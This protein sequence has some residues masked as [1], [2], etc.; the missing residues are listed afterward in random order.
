M[1]R[2]YLAEREKAL[3]TDILFLS[4]QGGSLDRHDILKTVARIA[5]R[6]KVL[7]AHPHRFRHTFAINFL[8]NGG[9]PYS[10][11]EILGHT[12]LDTVKIYL[13]IAN[14]DMF[15]AHQRASPV[16]KWGLGKL[17]AD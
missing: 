1:I 5:E 12:T 8:R 10:L 6:A 11:Q 9:D 17:P 13:Q 3:P 2:D 4:S 7:N 16:K 15:A 14:T